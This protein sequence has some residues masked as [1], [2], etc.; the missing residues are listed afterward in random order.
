M[1]FLD[2]KAKAQEF[3]KMQEK[4]RAVDLHNAGL[5]AYTKG[6]SDAQLQRMQEAYRQEQI[7]KQLQAQQNA[8]I[9]KYGAPV[10]TR[11]TAPMVPTKFGPNDVSPGSYKAPVQ[12]QGLGWSAAMGNGYIQ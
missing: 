1:G 3:D 8:Y 4:A 2:T 11:E 7:A 10:N 5:A 12:G 9:E 6:L